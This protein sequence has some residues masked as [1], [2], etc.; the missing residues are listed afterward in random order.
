MLTKK[1][2][3]LYK[4]LKHYFKENEIMPSFEEMKNYMNIKSK[5]GIFDMLGYIEWKGYIVKPTARW[6]AIQIKEMCSK[7]KQVIKEVA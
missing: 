2:L 6:R 4:Y 3:K 7:C 5:G 1:Q